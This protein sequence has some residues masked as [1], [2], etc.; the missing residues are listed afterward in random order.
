MNDAPHSNP[1]SVQ[2]QSG[3]DVLGCY[4]SPVNDAYWK[5]ALAGGRH[6]VRMCQLATADSGAACRHINS[7]DYQGAVFAPA[8]LSTRVVLHVPAGHHPIRLRR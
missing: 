8:L 6:R 5:A 7:A 4:M 3:F 2:L 1:F